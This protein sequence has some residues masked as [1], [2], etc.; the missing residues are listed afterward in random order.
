MQMHHLIRDR[1]GE[2]LKAIF[3]IIK[4]RRILIQLSQPLHSRKSFHSLYLSIELLG[5]HPNIVKFHG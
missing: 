5:V 3:Y 1:E 4:S 2:S